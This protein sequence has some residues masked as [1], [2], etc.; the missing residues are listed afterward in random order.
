MP[1]DRNV[2][3]AAPTATRAA[4]SRVRVGAAA[5][6]RMTTPRARVALTRAMGPLAVPAGGD[7]AADDRAGAHGRGEGAVGGGGAVEGVLGH[8]GQEDLELVGQ[9]PDDRH[10]RRANR[11]ARG[12]TGRSGS[13]PGA[14][15]WPDRSGARWQ[16]AD[17]HQAQ[18]G[19]HGQV[20]GGVDVEAGGQAHG[21]DEQAGDGRTDDPGRV[22]HDR[23]EG[24]G[25]RQVLGADHLQHE[26][27]ADGVVDRRHQSEAGGQHVDLP[28]LD[29][30][31]GDEHAEDEGGDGR[32]ELGDEQHPALLEPVHQDAPERAE[33]QD[34]QELEGDDQAE[35]GAG[36]GQLE[37]QP[38]LAD[39]LHPRAAHGD[40]L[41]D[42]VQ[43]VIADLQ[44]GERPLGD[45]AC[46]GHVVSQSN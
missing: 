8:E 21:G 12:S 9:R 30:V 23:V 24:D 11:A 46:P 38:G 37:D 40:G 28:E 25:V 31:G 15:P 2:I 22:E 1:R 36:A 17:L 10:H 41:A 32:R 5:A 14:G 7:Q 19:E 45:A 44:R 42:E 16:L 26:G 3:D 6:I 4:S 27:L 18:G 39:G 33:E 35:G 29:G 43:A 34:R 20:G 13:L